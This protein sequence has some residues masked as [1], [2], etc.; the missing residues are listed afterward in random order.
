MNQKAQRTRLGIFIITGASILLFLTAYFTAR[1]LFRKTETYY[2]SFRDI[3]VS[4]MEV[5]SQVRY[6]GIRVGTISAINIDPEDVSGIIVT[7]SLKPGL[8]IK[9]DSRADISS[10]GITGMKSIEIKGGTNEA[11]R[12]RPGSFIPSGGS[13]ADDISG[14]AEDIAVKAEQVVN[15]LLRLT[16]PE[17]TEKLVS[18]IDHYN[19]LA[20]NANRAVLRIDSLVMINQEN[21]NNTLSSA[22]VITSTLEKSS[23]RFSYAVDKAAGIVGNDSIRLIIGNLK[24]AS[25]KLRDADLKLM[26]EEISSLAAKVRLLLD[27]MDSDISSGSQSLSESLILLESTMRNLEEA[28]R[29]INSDPSVLLRQRRNTDSPDKRLDE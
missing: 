13:F 6:M 28:S 19:S 22:K 17:N 23:A 24:E 11:P 26:V 10:F 20:E 25:D 9:E 18:A 14:R 21:I 4:G 7:L 2:V 16:Q 1:E 12:L 5:G 8:P 29:Q 3:S 27:N 15:N